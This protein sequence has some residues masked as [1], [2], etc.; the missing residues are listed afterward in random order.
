MH[1]LL[2]SKLAFFFQ[3]EKTW[4]FENTKIAFTFIIPD[5]KKILDKLMKC[6]GL[7]NYGKKKKNCKISSKK[8]WCIIW[9][10]E[11]IRKRSKSIIYKVLLKVYWT[12]TDRWQIKG[13]TWMISTV[14]STQMHCMVQ[15]RNYH[16]VNSVSI[17]TVTEVTKVIFQ[18]DNTPSHSSLDV[19]E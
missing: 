8:M 5:L 1:I 16:P 9:I 13:K 3:Q 15:L 14:A 18:D 19:T 6:N 2:C 10:M 17:R 4:H 7:C 11:E 12:L